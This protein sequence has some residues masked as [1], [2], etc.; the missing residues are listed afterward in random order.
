MSHGQANLPPC[1]W[2]KCPLGAREEGS[3][4]SRDAW[5]SSACPRVLSFNWA[6][7]ARTRHG[8]ARRRPRDAVTYSLLHL[9]PHPG[10]PCTRRR[11]E[12]L[13]TP[14][15]EGL[16][17]VAT[18][19]LQSKPRSPHD[20]T[21]LPVGHSSEKIRATQVCYLPPLAT[22]RRPTLR[23]AMIRYVSCSNDANL[24][25]PG[26]DSQLSAFRTP[27]QK[28]YMFKATDK[29]LLLCKANTYNLGSH[30]S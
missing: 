22:G 16:F 28:Q 6:H 8:H 24:P 17:Y 12:H 5:A 20:C 7:A 10:H 4:W 1:A 11:R 18:L 30:E 2:P 29:P 3:S 14:L 23:R 19:A 13:S 26:V 15:G 25:L 21:Y 27:T 9:H